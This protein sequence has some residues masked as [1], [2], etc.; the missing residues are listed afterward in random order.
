M[1]QLGDRFVQQHGLTTA[2]WHG[3]VGRTFS[4]ENGAAQ[5]AQFFDSVEM[6]YYEDTLRVIEVE[7]LLRYYYS[8]GVIPAELEG[9]LRVFLQQEM[10]AQGGAIEIGKSTGLFVAR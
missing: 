1:W 5:L 3:T 10:D 9:D 4:L 6:L 8:M 7:P 2:D